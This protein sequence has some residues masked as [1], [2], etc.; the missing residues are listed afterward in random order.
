MEV[1]K[2]VLEMLIY[3][4]KERRKAMKIVSEL[5]GVNSI[6]ME[7]KEKKMTVTGEVDP[8]CVVRKLRK[9]RQTEIISVGPLKEEEKKKEDK[10]PEILDYRNN[11]PFYFIEEM[12]Y[13]HPSSC[14]IL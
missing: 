8:I 12:S 11:I 2:I 6:S 10:L 3:D 5:T 4:E 7:M 1:K 9:F 14:V 13:G